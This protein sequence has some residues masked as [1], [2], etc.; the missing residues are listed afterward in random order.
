MH[1]L[2]QLIFWTPTEVFMVWTLKSLGIMELSFSQKFTVFGKKSEV[3][4]DYYRTDFVNQIV[5]DWENP[6]EVNFYNLKGESYATSF[7][8]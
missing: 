7:Q 6:R 2:E 1:L 5:V 4:F 8:A 3:T